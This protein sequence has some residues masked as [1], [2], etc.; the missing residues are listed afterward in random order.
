RVKNLDLTRARKTPWV[1]GAIGPEDCHVL[2]REP[3]FQGAPI[4][5]VAAESAERA[6]EA[7]AL[8]E[9]EWE[10]LEPLLDPDEAVR[11]ESFTDAP[12]RS[13]CRATRCASSATSWAGV[14][15]PRTPPATT[16]SSR[17]PSR[18]RPGPLS[19]APSH[20]AR[21]T[22]S[23]ATATPPSSGSSPAPAPTEP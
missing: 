7:L 22:S 23:V 4:A 19:A 18:A 2:E 1:R 16:P 14:S 5:A 21:R 13:A 11:R 3:P 12:R 15:A 17:S 6:R 20:A 10:V 8:I 9:I